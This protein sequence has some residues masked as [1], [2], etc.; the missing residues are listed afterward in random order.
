[1]SLETKTA[2]YSVLTSDEALAA[3][4]GT[5]ENDDPA[6][7]NSNMNKLAQESGWSYPVVIFRE[8][9]GKADARFRAETVGTEIF[10][11]E[12]WGSS[13]KT[14]AEIF[15]EIDRI[16]HNQTLTLESGTCYD[17]VRIAQ[18]PDQY[19]SKLKIHFGLYRYKLVV[20]K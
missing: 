11:L 3:L 10:D 7:F 12:I 13:A 9:D 2:L 15:D 20:S 4:L 8:A 17:C 6:V 5:D 1:M 19:D 14:V 16:L 18:N